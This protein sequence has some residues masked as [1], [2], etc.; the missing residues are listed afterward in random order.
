[1]RQ[2]LGAGHI[3]MITII[4]IGLVALTG[5]ILIPRLTNKVNKTTCCVNAGGKWES[6]TCIPIQEGMYDEE[7]YNECIE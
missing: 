5:S 1:M 4:I 2:S 7:Q 3:T 6:N